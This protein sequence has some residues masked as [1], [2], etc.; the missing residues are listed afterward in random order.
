MMYNRDPYNGDTRDHTECIVI[1]YTECVI[2]N[3]FKWERDAWHIPRKI[4][5]HPRFTR[6]KRFIK[7]RNQLKYKFKKEVV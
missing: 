5:I 4:P 2:F 6:P 7:I 3:S 1:G